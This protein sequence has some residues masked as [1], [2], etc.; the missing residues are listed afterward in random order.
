MVIS[1]SEYKVEKYFFAFCKTI[2]KTL[3][4]KLTRYLIRVLFFT[5]YKD[6]GNKTHET[7]RLNDFEK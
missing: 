3:R 7:P 6:A 4:S 1:Q 5:S 2:F